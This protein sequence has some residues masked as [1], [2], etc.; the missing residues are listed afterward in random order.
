MAG[1]D[2]KLDIGYGTFAIPR[3]MQAMIEYARAKKRPLTRIRREKI[4]PLLGN[5]QA[6]NDRGFTT[7]DLLIAK[8]PL[9]W[10]E[11]RKYMTI[12]DLLQWGMTFNTAMDLGI[13]CDHMCGSAGVA[14]LQQMKA[15]VPQLL[16]IV[17]NVEDLKATGWTAVDVVNLGIN[18]D[19][20][21]SLGCNVKN[22]KKP[23]GWTIKNLVFAYS[24]KIT[25]QQW[26]DAGFTDNQALAC[27]YDMG[28]YR[29]FVAS[30][31]SRER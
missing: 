18:F 19:E 16:S 15:T 9:S 10:E 29:S 2:T 28:N 13:T 26:L 5:I 17:N 25:G 8:P 7:K 4:R 11:V 24:N 3:S 14:I 23:L 22:F 27:E 20:L 30:K 31:T 12:D 21:L 6:L 1:G